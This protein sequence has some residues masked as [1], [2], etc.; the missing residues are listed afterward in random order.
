[1]KGI[2]PVFIEGDH[3]QYYFESVVQ[4]QTLTFPVE[5]DKEFGQWKIMEY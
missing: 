2:K 1:M 5:F 4:G 3:A